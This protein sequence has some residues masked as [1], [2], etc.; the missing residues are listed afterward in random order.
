MIGPP[1]RVAGH[2]RAGAAS[3]RRRR[4]AAD[5]REEWLAGRG[6]L[7]GEIRLVEGGAR[8][9]LGDALARQ[10]RDRL[11]GI[12]LATATWAKPTSRPAISRRPVGD[13]KHQRM[14]IVGRQR[15]HAR[16]PGE[17]RDQARIAVLRA[18]GIR[19]GAGGVENQ[20]TRASFR[21]SGCGSGRARLG[22][23][24]RSRPPPAP[25]APGASRPTRA[26]S[27]RSRT[28]GR[29]AVRRRAAPG[30]VEDE[31]GL[32]LAV[33]RQDRV[34]HRAQARQR[35]AGTIASSVLGSIHETGVPGPTPRACSAYATRIAASR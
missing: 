34:L 28:C 19:G 24:Q 31:A 14:S 9:R 5:A 8:P 6:A 29:P 12:K 20:R 32:A 23:G 26:P 10:Q 30:L 4:E 15:Q 1:A 21:P 11:L 7:G 25:R 35:L 2:E 13:R 27:P 22:L 18:L 33:D 17:S 3:A 16:H